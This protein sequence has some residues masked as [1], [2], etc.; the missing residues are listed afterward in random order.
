M[1]S[2]ERRMQQIEYNE[3]VK[4][5]RAYLG[6]KNYEQALQ[7]ASRAAALTGVENTDEAYELI[8]TIRKA[9]DEQAAAAQQ[10][11][12]QAL[13]QKERRT[14]QRANSTLM[15]VARI[16]GVLAL[17]Y[18]VSFLAVPLMQHGFEYFVNYI[19]IQKATY[20]GGGC[21]VFYTLMA[22]LADAYPLGGI[23]LPIVWSGILS[24]FISV[25][26][27]IAY[28]EQSTRLWPRWGKLFVILIVANIVAVAISSRVGKA[29]KGS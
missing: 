21:I 2:F 26:T 18:S 27:C 3:A 12:A 5:A 7:E 1:D 17:L 9:A 11:Q 16:L 15:R 8:A 4:A 19:D 28:S 14:S 22:F 25:S 20:I 29:V 10:Q 13:I 24:F 23:A 6:A